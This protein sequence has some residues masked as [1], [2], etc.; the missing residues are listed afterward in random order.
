[1]TPLKTAQG[2]LDAWTPEPAQP[3]PP[4]QHQHSTLQ[5]RVYSTWP[6]HLQPH[7]GW[8]GRASTVCSVVFSERAWRGDNGRLSTNRTASLAFP[9]PIFRLPISPISPTSPTSV[10]V[11]SAKTHLACLVTSLHRHLQ[12]LAM[13]ALR[14]PSLHSRHQQLLSKRLALDRVHTTR[15]SIILVIQNSFLD[16]LHPAL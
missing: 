16:T 10:L 1:M 6:L 4:V 13:V 9:I 12:V 7:D 2:R 15:T 11:V 5:G 8:R 3:R 14:G